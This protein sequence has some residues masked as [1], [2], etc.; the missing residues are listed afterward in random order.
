[1]PIVTIVLEFDEMPEKT[2]IINYIQELIENDC[3]DYSM[4]KKDE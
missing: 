2:D 4:E 3:L 1:M